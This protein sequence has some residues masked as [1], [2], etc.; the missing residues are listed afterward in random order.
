MIGFIT[1]GV[2]SG[3]IL[4]FVDLIPDYITYSL[5]NSEWAGGYQAEGLGSQA[6]WWNTKIQVKV[7]PGPLLDGTPCL[8]NVEVL[9]LKCNSN[10][11]DQQR[12]H[13]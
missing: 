6:I 1:K 3:R 9:L 5:P 8:S 2:P 11:R 4:G 12:D 7:H 13:T 10:A